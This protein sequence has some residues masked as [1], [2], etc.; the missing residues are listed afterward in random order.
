MRLPA[1]IPFACETL[2]GGV[3]VAVG[4]NRAGSGRSLSFLEV[5]LPAACAVFHL[6]K[7]VSW[8]RLRCPDGVQHHGFEVGLWMS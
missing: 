3:V 8:Y 2:V 4:T 1:I 7:A 6:A 5:S